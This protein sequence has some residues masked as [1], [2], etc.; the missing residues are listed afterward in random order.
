[1][2]RKLLST[3]VP[4]FCVAGVLALAFGYLAHDR[5]GYSRHQIRDAA[6]VSASLL[7]TLLV[8]DYLSKL[9]RAK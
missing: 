4:A 2:N 9:R 3:L 8:V 7:G 6:I 5:L 1:M